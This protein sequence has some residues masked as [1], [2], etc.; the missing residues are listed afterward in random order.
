LDIDLLANGLLPLGSFGDDW[1]KV[2]L[3]TIRLNLDRYSLRSFTGTGTIV[4]SASLK[5]VLDI[6]ISPDLSIGREKL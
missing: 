4:V 3:T 6:F 5:I 2:G 1:H